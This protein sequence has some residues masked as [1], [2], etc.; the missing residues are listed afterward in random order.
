LHSD[1]AQDNLKKILNDD[2]FQTRLDSRL[3]A[4]LMAIQQEAL[5]K[6]EQSGLLSGH[7]GEALRW[8]LDTELTLLLDKEELKGEVPLPKV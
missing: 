1:I 6:A 8:K 2:A 7:I 4:R 5:S 3:E